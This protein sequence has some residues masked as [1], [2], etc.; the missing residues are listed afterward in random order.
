MRGA[1]SQ[2][3]KPQPCHAPSRPSPG[4]EGREGW[5][6]EGGRRGRAVRAGGVGERGR[7]EPWWQGDVA[8]PRDA[9]G[10]ARRCA[11]SGPGA[12]G[13]G[14][15]ARPPS[16]EEARGIRSARA[17]QLCSKLGLPAAQ[18]RLSVLASRLHFPWSLRPRRR[19]AAAAPP[20]DSSEQAPRQP[21]AP[22]LR[23]VVPS[24]SAPTSR[25]VDRS[26]QGPPLGQRSLAARRA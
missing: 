15:R 7:S 25:P 4:G 23:V 10:V 6:A 1:G 5:G 2:P 12:L 20:R 19:E 14:R 21:T 24:F 3:H 26:S 8:P 18:R 11:P 17:P 9:L 13:R 16:G 22:G